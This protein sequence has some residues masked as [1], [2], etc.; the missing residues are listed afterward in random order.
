MSHVVIQLFV[1]LLLL[2]L[3]AILAKQHRR[4]IGDAVDTLTRELRDATRHFRMFSAET[5]RGREAEF[6]RDRLSQ[7]WPTM[8]LVAIL[9]LWAAAEW[10]LT[11]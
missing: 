9:V 10:W 3:L 7:H 4:E 11:R 8:L 5:T 6:I 1:T 2:L